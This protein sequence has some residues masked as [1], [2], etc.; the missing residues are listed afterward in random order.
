MKMKLKAENE[1][2]QNEASVMSKDIS[3]LNE[4]IILLK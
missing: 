4:E 1:K 3:K 2:Y